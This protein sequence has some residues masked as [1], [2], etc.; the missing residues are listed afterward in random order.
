MQQFKAR[1]LVNQSF[2]QLVN[3]PPRFILVF[4]DGQIETIRQRVFVNWFF[5]EY[6]RQFTDTPMLVKHSLDYALKGGSYASDTH[7]VLCENIEEVI[8]EKHG[9]TDWDLN[10][11]LSK[12]A[13]DSSIN[14]TNSLMEELAP[15][16]S[17]LDLLD[18][19]E[20]HQHPEI[21]AILEQGTDDGRTVETEYKVI[22]RVIMEDRSLDHNGLAK[23]YRGGRVKREQVL[24]TIGRRGVATEPDGQLFQKSTSTGYLKGFTK[25]FDFASDSR[26]APKAQI[27]AEAPLQDSE[28]LA[29]RLQFL[30]SVVT[31]IE[32]ID[33]GTT[34]YTDWFI[35]AEK[36][37]DDG[38]TL[39]TKGG[40]KNMAGMMYYDDDNN[41]KEI[42]GNER[43]MNGTYIRL[44]S[45]LT[46]K[47]KDPHTVC[48]TCFG[49]LWRNYYNHQ[50]LGHLCTVTFTEKVTQNTLSTKH[51]VSTG[52]GARIILTPSMETFFKVG[53]VKTNYHLQNYLK[54]MQL[55][56][57]LPHNEVYDL[58]NIVQMDDI[59][60]L[61]VKQTSR[62]SNVKFIYR[63]KGLETD[64]LVQVN[65][66][67]RMAYI[68]LEFMK[69]IKDHGYVVDEENNYLVD[70]ASWDYDSPL[71]SVPQMEI[72]YSEHGQE[73]GKLIESNMSKID[74][75]QKPE[76]PV[77][78]AQ[79]L[80]TLV[81]SKLD[82]PLSCLLVL[83]YASMVPSRNNPA[84]ARGWSKP[85]LGIARELIWNRSMST[86]YAFQGHADKMLN[87]RAFFPHFR[88]DNQ[89]DVFFAP[90]KVVENEKRKRG[91][92][93]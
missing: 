41:L 62:I 27:S 69:Y 15:F 55:K 43:H 60:D 67:N 26:S 10:A 66:S 87:A 83:I 86:G 21:Q 93:P 48:R 33:C 85:V 38:K 45:I 77:N 6:H 22:H 56:L 20:I 89:M 79:E 57:A 19:I 42:K 88:P 9:D 12:I 82:V 51:L 4:D 44:R 52:E 35:D 25:I 39:I 3:L 73:V 23:A 78:T 17:P 11:K 90:Q 46:C 75:R 31:K 54:K 1:D 70:L 49:G 64:R 29:R 16:V 30:A 91:L 59:E 5:W 14:M 28:Y 63:E 47:N 71:F 65:Q 2:A 40:I 58:A 72:S 92:I 13:Y 32:G 24:Q 37:D 76:S 80:Y 8:Y 74:E 61:R 36:L 81:N 53:K 18:A 7:L 68:T 50:N 84:L 34:E